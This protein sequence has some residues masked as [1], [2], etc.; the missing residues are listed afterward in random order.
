MVTAIGLGERGFL[1][2]SY[3]AD[4]IGAEIVRP[5]AQDQADAAGRGVHQHVHALLDLKGAAQQIF[6]VMP[7]SIMA[8]ACS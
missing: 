8:A 4:D 1:L 5:L 2:R 6:A 3:R 7:L